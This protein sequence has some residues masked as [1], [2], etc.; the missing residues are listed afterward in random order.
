MN[1]NSKILIGIIVFVIFF[2]SDRYVWM[3][4]RVEQ[5]WLQQSGRN[6]GDPIAYNQDF[7]LSDSK[8]IFHGIKST[9]EYPSVMGNRKSK[10][11]LVGCYFGLLYIY[12]INRKE[13]TTYSN[14]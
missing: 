14:I 12:D 4:K 3:P 7:I 8:V 6:L 10:F 2:I 13:I 9:N 1:K 5:V 11:Y